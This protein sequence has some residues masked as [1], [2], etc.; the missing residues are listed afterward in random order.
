MHTDAPRLNRFVTGIC[1]TE[2]LSNTSISRALTVHTRLH[3]TTEKCTPDAE[4]V[5]EG[6]ATASLVGQC[7]GSG[8]GGL[9]CFTRQT[10][11]AGD[12]SNAAPT[13]ARPVLLCSMPFPH[14]RHCS[15]TLC[16]SLTPS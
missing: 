13:C 14:L 1:R 9:V 6:C 12:V 3:Y 4:Q 8:G 5:D 10:D 16:Y 11:T 15:T 7:R 2:V